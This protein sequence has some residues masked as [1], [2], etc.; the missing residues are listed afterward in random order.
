M[1]LQ[2]ALGVALGTVL[3][4]VLKFLLVQFLEWGSRANLRG[5]IDRLLGYGAVLA[6]LTLLAIVV[7][8]R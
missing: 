3:V 7:W 1:I 5:M 8:G 2:I 6:L 4:G